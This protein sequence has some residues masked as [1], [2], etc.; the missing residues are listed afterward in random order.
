MLRTLLSCRGCC[1]TRAVDTAY[2][3]L[4]PTACSNVMLILL[5]PIPPACL[6]TQTVP[7]LFFLL[8]RSPVPVGYPPS[9]NHF[10]FSFSKRTKKN[11]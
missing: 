6:C 2:R 1:A 8:S 10:F 11:S 3:A 9:T 5:L 7:S 4:C